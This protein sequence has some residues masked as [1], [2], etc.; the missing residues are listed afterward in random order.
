MHADKICK[1]IQAHSILTFRYKGSIRTVE[2]HT[3]GYDGD[4]DLT[5][6]AWQLS[7]G[8]GVGFRDFHVQKLSELS[9]A[10]Q[11]FSGARP[12]FRRGDQT[13]S[14]ILCQL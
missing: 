13:L 6:C 10:Q 11:S 7:G 12:G 2:P 8:S 1:A 5:L 14:R 9:T 3:L 4:G